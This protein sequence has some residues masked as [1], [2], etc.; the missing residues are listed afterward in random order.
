MILVAAFA[1][2]S[3]YAERENKNENFLFTYDSVAECARLH[4]LVQQVL[5]LS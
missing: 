5:D 3:V 2:Y 1:N 4:A